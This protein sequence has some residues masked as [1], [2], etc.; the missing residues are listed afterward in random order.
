MPQNIT[1]NECET[2]AVHADRT[3]DGVTTDE[4]IAAH[5]RTLHSGPWPSPQQ[6]KLALH[7]LE[8]DALI[9]CRA[10]PQRSSTVLPT[11]S[12]WQFA[13]SA[14]LAS[15][16]ATPEQAPEIKTH[17]FLRNIAGYPA[18]HTAS[19]RIC[20]ESWRIP[21]RTRTAQDSRTLN[22]STRFHGRNS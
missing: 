18:R 16:P 11:M 4:G 21:R 3:A 5:K 9:Q 2:L 10:S 14:A 13:P 6:T 20:E 1:K 7:I 22:S 19:R 12:G 15:S 8:Q 17:K